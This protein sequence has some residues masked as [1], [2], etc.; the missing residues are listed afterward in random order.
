MWYAFILPCQ[1][2]RNKDVQ[3]TYVLK[4][5]F[6]YFKAPHLMLSLFMWLEM[7]CNVC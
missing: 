7:D 1:E 6:T 5:D 3:S 2:W 4:R